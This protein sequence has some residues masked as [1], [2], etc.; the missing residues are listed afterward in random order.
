[1]SSTYHPQSNGQSEMMNQNPEGY[2]SIGQAL[3]LLLRGHQ[4]EYHKP[5]GH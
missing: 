2:N 5:Q 4:F 1:M 3:G